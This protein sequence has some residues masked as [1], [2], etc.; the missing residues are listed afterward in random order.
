MKRL[1]RC[2][3][4]LAIC[5]L[6]LALSP[7]L[8]AAETVSSKIE[9]PSI[10]HWT[11]DADSAEAVLDHSGG[12]NN[13]TFAVGRPSF[14]DGLFDKAIHFAGTHRLQTPGKP[15]F[16]KS[17]RISLSAWVLPSAFARHNEIFRKEDGD[18]RVL[19]S[20]QENGH[21]LSLGLNVGGYV[22]CDAPI[23]P[24][25]VLDGLWH[26][27]AA[28]FDGKAMRVYL[29]GREIGSLE[30]PGKI[31]AGGTAAGCIGS[32]N[33]R[34]CF[35]GAMDD[36]RIYGDALTGE[37]VAQLYDGGR[38]ML[39][40]YREKL[41]KKLLAHKERLRSL[42]ITGESLTE[43]LANSRRSL[44]ENGVPLND[45]IVGDAL[46]LLST[47]YA[48]D[49]RAFASRAGMTPDQYLRSPDKGL[50]AKLAR[51]LIEPVV[52]YMPLTENQ[53]KRQSPEDLK[54]WKEIA[55]IHRKYEKLT[56]LGEAAY[57][58]PEWI[59]VLVEAYR[60]SGSVPQRP[61]VQEAVAPYVKPSTPATRSLPA[62]TA[63]ES[64]RR[65]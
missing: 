56:K 22:E 30:R 17:E 20:F 59:D 27:C 28:T 57:N 32:T 53:W 18:K 52:E 40:Q 23:K 51:R 65:D 42:N 55:A 29:D 7:R 64:L 34:E 13:A 45:P 15:D 41:E 36:L 46:K 31:A 35:Q 26:H 44:V 63:R 2:I 21:V 6:S 5:L 1:A 43:A 47:R 61:R 9:K 19:F 10:A 24:T 62:D 38:R 8:S 4:F 16:S 12:G 37:E 48:E 49:Y 14:G 60:R 58:S 3:V 33:G 54:R 50:N 25:Q 39:E 11:F